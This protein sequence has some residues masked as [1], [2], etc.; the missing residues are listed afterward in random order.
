MLGKYSIA[1]THLFKMLAPYTKTASAER[2]SFTSFLYLELDTPTSITS[3]FTAHVASLESQQHSCENLD[4]G[5][6][7]AVLPLQP[8]LIP[9]P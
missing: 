8:K 6:I 5:G 2:P 9:T 1:T 3:P 7:P 4:I